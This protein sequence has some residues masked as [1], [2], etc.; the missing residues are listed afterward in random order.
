MTNRTPQPNVNERAWTSAKTTIMSGLSGEPYALI[1]A[2]LQVR[3]LP[4]PP[5]FS[6]GYERFG[7]QLRPGIAALATLVATIDAIREG[8]C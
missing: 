4:G 8:R 3:V 2:W 7:W 5:L 6:M 1:T